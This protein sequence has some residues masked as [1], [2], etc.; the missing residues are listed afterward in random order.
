MC[1]EHPAVAG[2]NPV[3]FV[4]QH[5]VGKAK[6]AD[7]GGNLRDLLVAVRARVSGVGDQAHRRRT[8]VSGNVTGKPRLCFIEVKK[9]NFKKIHANH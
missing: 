6:F 5:R 4:D 1:A 7:R 2:D 8:M 3:L 9:S